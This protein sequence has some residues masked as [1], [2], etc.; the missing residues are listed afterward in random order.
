MGRDFLETIGDIR[1]FYGFVFYFF[2]RHDNDLFL[3]DD[4][5]KAEMSMCFQ[6]I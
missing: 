2:Y 6:M 5:N 1:G 4:M 3:G